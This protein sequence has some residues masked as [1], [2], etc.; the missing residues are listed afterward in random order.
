MVYADRHIP[1]QGKQCQAEHR[2][3]IRTSKPMKLKHE[4][5]EKKYEYKSSLHQCH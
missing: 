1:F 4:K 3:G 2:K 5:W